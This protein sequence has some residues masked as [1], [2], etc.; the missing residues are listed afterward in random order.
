MDVTNLSPKKVLKSENEVEDQ[1]VKQNEN[2]P[3]KS[4]DDILFGGPVK[5]PEF[6]FKGDA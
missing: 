1:K 5:K 6:K 4:L 2:V 3:Q